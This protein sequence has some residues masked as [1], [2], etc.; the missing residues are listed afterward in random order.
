MIA[1]GGRLMLMQPEMPVWPTDIRAV[2]GCPTP[3]CGAMRT[4]AMAKMELARPVLACPSPRDRVRLRPA[5]PPGPAAHEGSKKD[6]SETEP[7]QYADEET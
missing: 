2:Q 1:V 3:S 5:P 7:E 4:A 6:P